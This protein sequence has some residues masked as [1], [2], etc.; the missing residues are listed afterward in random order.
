MLGGRIGS[1][2]GTGIG[3]V[4]GLKIDA[5]WSVIGGMIGAAGALAA[6]SGLGLG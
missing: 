5:G 3:S 4:L 6:S 1:V 2:L